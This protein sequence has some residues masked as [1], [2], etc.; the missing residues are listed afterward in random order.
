MNRQPLLCMAQQ[1]KNNFK[2]A[3]GRPRRVTHLPLFPVCFRST[4]LTR[5]LAIAAVLAFTTSSNSRFSASM[6]MVL[7]RDFSASDSARIRSFLSQKKRTANRPPT[8]NCIAAASRDSIKA[9]P[10]VALL[11]TVDPA[12]R[13][14]S[15]ATPSGAIVSRYRGQPV[16]H[17]TRLDRCQWRWLPCWLLAV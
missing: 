7:V 10:V 5:R 17:P 13:K 4:K 3:V 1:K 14:D 12:H 16:G 11:S 2:F 8:P 9:R 15:T 6:L